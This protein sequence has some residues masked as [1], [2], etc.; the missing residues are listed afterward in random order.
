MPTVTVAVDD[1]AR[2]DVQALVTRHLA[3]ARAHSDPGAVFALDGDSL[4][5]P[6]T[7]LVAARVHGRLLG[8]GALR[9]LGAGHGE[10][11]SMHTAAEARG[12][13]VATAVVGCLLDLAR[14]RGHHRV[15]LETGAAEAFRPARGL[16]ARCG[17]VTC[18]PFGGYPADTDSVFMTIAL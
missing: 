14:A 18:G 16:Y 6:S 8:I 12:T 4:A 13:G 17:F 10:L 2:S 5:D 1:P 7:T 9:D 3:F 15:S 11:K